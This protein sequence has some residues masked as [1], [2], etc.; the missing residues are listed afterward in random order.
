MTTNRLKI[1]NSQGRVSLLV[2]QFKMTSTEIIYTWITK[3]N[4]NK[5]ILRT[6]K[7]LKYTQTQH[8]H[9]HTCIHTHTHTRVCVC[10]CVC[11]RER[12]RERIINTP[13][14]KNQ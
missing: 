2:I 5:K 13:D 14:S 7:N 1:S 10:V 4:K 6:I 11:V 3:K 9:I 8:I 12:E